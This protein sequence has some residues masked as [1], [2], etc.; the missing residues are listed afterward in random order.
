MKKTYSV[1]LLLMLFVAGSVSAQLRHVRTM[2]GVEAG[3]GVTGH[4][5]LFYGGFMTYLSKKSYF[6]PI[7]FMERGAQVGIRYQSVGADV[8]FAYTFTKVGSSVYVNGFAGATASSDQRVGAEG[9]ANFEIPTTFKY[10]VLAGLEVETF[11]SDRFVFVLNWNQRML[12][13]DAFGRNRWFGT[14]GIRYNF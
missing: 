2:K 9:T 4:G 13:R 3:Y 7:V 1:C 14:T 5:T 8:A 6:K 10:G 11:I 12:L